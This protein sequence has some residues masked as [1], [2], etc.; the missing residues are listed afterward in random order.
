MRRE[1]IRILVSDANRRERAICAALADGDERNVRL[2]LTAAL[3][4]CPKAAIP[5]VV[6]RIRSESA[7]D[8]QALAV[9]VIGNTDQSQTL[10]ILLSVAAP[11]KQLFGTKLPPKSEAYLAAL[12]SL[13]K[14]FADNPRARDV[15]A[16]AARSRDP[17]VVRAALGDVGTSRE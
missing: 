6:S 4:G 9:K 3:D 14:R 16:Q 8:L 5:M 17:E 15:L 1:A 11:R 12:R 13:K 7:D 2:G 10:D